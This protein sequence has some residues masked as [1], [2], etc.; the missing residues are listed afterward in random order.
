MNINSD[1]NAVDIIQATL[2]DGGCMVELF[3]AMVVANGVFIDN[4]GDVVKSLPEDHK[5]ALR[6]MLVKLANTLADTCDL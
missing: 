4:F 2:D 3:Q 5:R 1:V 6:I